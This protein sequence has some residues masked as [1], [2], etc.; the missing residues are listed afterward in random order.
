[1]ISYGLAGA[2]RHNS[3]TLIYVILGFHLA[4]LLNLHEITI[5]YRALFA[6][7]RPIS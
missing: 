5:S 7:N 2:Y 3:Y 1:M 4:N 6:P